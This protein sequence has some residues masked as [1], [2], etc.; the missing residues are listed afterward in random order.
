M[1]SGWQAFAQESPWH[2]QV[3][4]RHLSST[5]FYSQR[6]SGTTFQLGVTADGRV[7]RAA[8]LP[9]SFVG[10]RFMR[11]SLPVA[12]VQRFVGCSAEKNGCSP[13]V[14]KI[15]ATYERPNRKVSRCM[16][17]FKV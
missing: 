16:K 17:T 6:F 12:P 8:A 2:H 3:S 15:L 14:F 7:D 1:R 5:T 10:R 13:G 9:S 4:V 11:K